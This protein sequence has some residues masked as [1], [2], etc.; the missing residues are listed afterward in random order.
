MSK[1]KERLDLL[2]V[3]RGLVASRS[4]G[5]AM[6]MA[7][8][9]LVD[10]EPV[11]KPGA[12]VPL[13]ADVRVVQAPP[14]VSRGGLKLAAA[15][16]E[17][18]ITPAGRVCA[19]VG[20]CTGGFTDVLLQAGAKRVYAIDV[21]YGQLDWNLRR[22]PRVVV[23]ERTNVRYLGSLPEPIELVAV[24]VS[25]I[26][27]RLVLPVVRNWM[28]E[29]GHVVA[30]IKPQF[31]AGRRQVKKGGVVKDTEVHR[32]VLSELLNWAMAG[33]WGVTGLT[34]SPVQGASGNVEFLAWLRA[35]R[36]TT[37]ALTRAIERV[38]QTGGVDQGGS[39]QA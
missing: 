38:L 2:L 3:E 32:Q 35:G 5:Q 16:S 13:G 37:L 20:A 24:D 12:Q 27:L 28:A 1:A 19:D 36:P 33:G 21:G 29:D 23:M 22:D 17:F 6:I 4:R 25:F 8:E 7:G 39:S 11:T 10:G 31:E 30:L 9:V 14:Y 34:R 26:S 18:G 15:L